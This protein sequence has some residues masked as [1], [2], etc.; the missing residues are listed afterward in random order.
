MKRTKSCAFFYRN[1]NYKFHGWKLQ[2]LMEIQYSPEIPMTLSARKI[3]IFGLNFFHNKKGWHFKISEKVG[4]KHCPSSFILALSTRCR[5]GATRLQV[6]VPLHVRAVHRTWIWGMLE[7][8]RPGGI[9]FR[10]EI[11]PVIIKLNIF[12]LSSSV[13]PYIIIINCLTRNGWYNL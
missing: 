3:R 6:Q 10:V 7:C 12:N 9:H 4:E 13:F 1:R 11:V 8:G 2:I 5:A